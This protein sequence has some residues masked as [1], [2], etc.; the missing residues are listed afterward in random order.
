M[1][2]RHFV[3]IPELEVAAGKR[4]AEMLKL[5]DGYTAHHS[6]DIGGRITDV[7]GSPAMYSTLVNAHEGAFT[8]A[9]FDMH[10]LPGKKVPVDALSAIGTGFGIAPAINYSR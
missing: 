8:G 9:T 4:I 5:P 7:T 10:A 1:A 6:V 2:G 3:N